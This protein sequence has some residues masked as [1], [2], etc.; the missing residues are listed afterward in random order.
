[1]S[2]SSITFGWLRDGLGNLKAAREIEDNF[3]AFT[4]GQKFYCDPSAI[5]AS[6]NNL[7]T[8]KREPLATVQAGLDLMTSGNHDILYLGGEGGHTLADELV[9]TKDRLHIVGTGFRGGAHQGQRSRL[10]LGVTTGA[11]IAAI[12]ITGTGVTLNNLKISSAD[13]LSTSL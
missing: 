9:I 1:M 12:K 5:N 4:F 3:G 13:T 7:G 11:A 8:S 10:T 6:D 2:L